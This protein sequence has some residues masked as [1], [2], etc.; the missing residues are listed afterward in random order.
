MVA[1]AATSAL[2]A[3]LTLLPLF[4]VLVAVAI[5]ASVALGGFLLSG[6]AL[7][8]K[9]ERLNPLKG[10]G[11]MFSAQTLVELLKT[12][13]KAAVIGG[14]GATVIWHY[15]DDMIALMYTTPTEALTLGMKLVALC[16]ALIV[17]S[18]LLVELGRASCG[19][20]V[21]QY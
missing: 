15:R 10:I 8:P 1:L 16:C 7:E 11:R 14:I 17:A 3:I 2:E 18:L 6:K 9:F 12:L 21:C 4:G 19:E 5:L 20:R 13:A